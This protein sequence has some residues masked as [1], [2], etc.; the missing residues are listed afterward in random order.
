[1]SDYSDAIKAP[2]RKITGRVEIELGGHDLLVFEGEDIFEI[3]LLEEATGAG[4]SPLGFVTSNELTVSLNN[5]DRWFTPS[6]PDRLFDVRPGLEI[7]AY[8]IIETAGGDVEVSLGTFYT[9]EWDTPSNSIEAT[10]TC[11]DRLMQIINLDTPQIPVMTDTTVAGMFGRLFQGLGLEPA[12]FVVNASLTQPIKAGWFP[13]DTVGVSLQVLAEAG[14]C[15][16]SVDRHNRITVQPNLRSGEPLATFTD[17]DMLFSV[18]NPQRI[19]DIYTAIKMQYRV[20]YLKP[21]NRNL[22]RADNLV[23]PDG[24]ITLDRIDFHGDDVPVMQVDWVYLY[25]PEFTGEV[26]DLFV[27]EPDGTPSGTFK[28]YDGT[29]ETGN[30]AH[31]ATNTTIQGEL[32]G[33]YGAGNAEVSGADRDFE[34]KF[35]VGVGRTDLSAD[36]SNLV[37]LVG[38]SLLRRTQYS[39]QIESEVS[40]IW[41]GATD[42]ILQVD[43][44]SGYAEEVNLEVKGIGTGHHIGHNV[45]TDAEAVTNYGHKELSL[46]NYLIQSQA[47]ARAYSELLINYVSDPLA[48]FEINYRGDPAIQV[49]DIIRVQSTQDKIP[50][51][52]V[53]VRRIELNYDGGLTSKIRCRRAS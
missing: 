36:F 31:D 12:E 3:S 53:M 7:R 27:G 20:P 23:I 10:T 35:T 4:P 9:G 21:A 2:I 52:D 8:L 34:I 15:F 49:G 30:I 42:I 11:H 38:S 43:N 39:G 17:Q 6:N 44:D 28:L 19:N 37:N 33:I 46:E 51:T 25:G 5:A 32:E 1:M 14:N 29:D 16:V 40:F 24:G 45:I 41:F 22:V 26:W 47:V 50:A 18:N 48:M 13:R